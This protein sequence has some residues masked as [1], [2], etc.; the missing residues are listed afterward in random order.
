MKINQ[1]DYF[2]LIKEIDSLNQSFSFMMKDLLNN[3][4]KEDFKNTVLSLNQMQL[5]NIAE[6]LQIKSR[7]LEEVQER[8]KSNQNKN[9][10]IKEMEEQLVLSNN[11]NNFKNIISKSIDSLN[12]IWNLEGFDSSYDT[13][14]SN[15]GDIHVQFNLNPLF[16]NEFFKYEEYYEQVKRKNEN[17]FSDFILSNKQPF[18]LIDCDKNKKILTGILNELFPS[19]YIIEWKN[20]NRHDF[21]ALTYVNCIIENIS[22]I[23]IVGE[24]K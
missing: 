1:D 23:K 16:T 20:R 4:L 9:K 21:F 5:S 8:A 24:L 13:F 15:N 7:C 6:R 22:D 12:Y 19:I 18:Y 11:F 3:E 14:I 10:L 17:D 2:Y